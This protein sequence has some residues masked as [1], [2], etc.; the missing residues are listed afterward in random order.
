VPLLQ[1]LACSATGWAARRSVANRNSTEQYKRDG[2]SKPHIGLLWLYWV[3]YMVAICLGYATRREIRNN[4]GRIEGEGMAIAGI[5][6]GWI[7]IG[8]LALLI[9]VFMYLRKLDTG[10]LG[11]RET[12]ATAMVE[13][14]RT[15]QE[16]FVCA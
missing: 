11:M 3:G 15:T 13:R 16:R 2:H 6:L 1:E 5:V 8:M 4:A 14:S 9:V 12:R 10:Q 7:E